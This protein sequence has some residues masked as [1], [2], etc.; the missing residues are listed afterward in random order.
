[1]TKEII[2]IAID[3]PCASGKS[4]FAQILKE[5]YDANLFRMD[6]FFLQSYQRKEE[7]LREIGGNIDYE[8]FEEEVLKNIRRGFP[9]SYRKYNCKKEVFDQVIEVNEKSI[10]IVEGVYS[11][12]PQLFPYYDKTI[13]LSIPRQEQLRRLKAREPF[14]FY[15]RFINEWIPLEDRYFKEF[16]I[17]KKASISLSGLNLEDLELHL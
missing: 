14:S 6:D 2:I 1:M 4:S 8:R 15:N 9:F 5:R 3:G 11:M 13:Y 17:E 16:D 7:R 10:N 12:H